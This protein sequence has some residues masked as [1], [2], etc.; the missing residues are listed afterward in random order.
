[1]SGILYGLTHLGSLELKVIHSRAP[2]FVQMSDDTI[3]NKYDVKVLNK[4]DSDVEVMITAEGPQGVEIVDGDRPLTIKPGKLAS[5]ILYIKV[6]NSNLT[7]SREPLKFRVYD[8][9][10]PEEHVVTYESAFFGPE[11]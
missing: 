11:R 6:P 5:R 9:A 10:K 7:Q 8:I 1:M 2:L 4:L 3:Q